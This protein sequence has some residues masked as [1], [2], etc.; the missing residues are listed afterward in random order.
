MM[1]CKLIQSVLNIGI[2]I[3]TADLI[4]KV[5]VYLQYRQ[6]HIKLVKQAREHVTTI[7]G[8]IQAWL[9]DNNFVTSKYGKEATCTCIAALLESPDMVQE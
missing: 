8:E 2:S 9:P 4:A 1:S 3:G 7:D 5:I 6:E